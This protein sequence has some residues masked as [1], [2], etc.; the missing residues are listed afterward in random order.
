MIENAGIIII[1]FSATMVHDLRRV[2]SETFFKGTAEIVRNIK[3]CLIDDM[4]MHNYIVVNKSKEALSG[5]QVYI[6]NSI[7]NP[8]HG[9][10]IRQ[11]LK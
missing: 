1:M 11:F 8:S 4:D 2:L 10:T 3:T 5:S 6:T 9:I 7:F